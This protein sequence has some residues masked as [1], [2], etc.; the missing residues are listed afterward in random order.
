MSKPEM[1]EGQDKKPE[2]TQSMSQEIG[3]LDGS[4][5]SFVKRSGRITEA[6]RRAIKLLGPKYIIPFSEELLILEELFPQNRPIILEIGFGSGQAT[7]RIAQERPEF[8]YL[9]IEVYASGVGRLIMDLELHAIENVRILQQDAIAV[10]RH[11]IA[12]RS[13]G[14]IHVF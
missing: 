1:E 12:P 7:W 11:M 2:Q 14:G 10:L 5:R 4:I 3:L 6:Q 9:G 13:L 8:N